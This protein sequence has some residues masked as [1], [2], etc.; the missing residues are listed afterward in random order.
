MPVFKL[1]IRV[2]NSTLPKPNPLRLFVLNAL[3]YSLVC[4]ACRG[5]S[6]QSILI[7]SIASHRIFPQD[8]STRTL[9]PP[10]KAEPCSK[11]P[12]WNVAKHIGNCTLCVLPTFKPRRRPGTE[13]T[14]KDPTKNGASPPVFIPLFTRKQCRWICGHWTC[15]D[16]YHVHQ[17]KQG[18]SGR[19]GCSLKN[20]RK[21]V[22]YFF[23]NRF[24]SPFA[25][26]WHLFDPVRL[27]A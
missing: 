27:H 2:T 22:I 5:Q 13:T 18:Q 19:Q 11:R 8:H 14:K 7:G 6:S 23:S 24:D 1:Q 4:L 12:S 26:K 9:N 15:G 20:R 10:Q 17:T 21:S 16:T 25:Q 3:S